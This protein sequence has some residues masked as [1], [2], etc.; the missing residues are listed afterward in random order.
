MTFTD[1]DINIAGQQ[2]GFGPTGVK[3]DKG[4]QG[5]PGAFLIPNYL[6]GLTLANNASNPTTHLDISPGCACSD[7]N[8]MMMMLSAALTKN[9]NAA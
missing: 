3:G 5:L 7:D 1:W 4:D 8:V 2:G 6:G 9:C